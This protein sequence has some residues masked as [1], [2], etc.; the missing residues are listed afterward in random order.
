MHNLWCYRSSVLELNIL[1][2]QHSPNGTFK[3]GATSVSSSH[4]NAAVLLYD[5]DNVYS[6]DFSSQNLTKLL[7][8]TSDHR[9]TDIKQIMRID[10]QSVLALDT[11]SDAIFYVSATNQTPEA[12]VCAKEGCCKDSLRCHKSSSL[13][14]S[15]IAVLSNTKNIVYF[16]D[17]STIKKFQIG[18]SFIY[19]KVLVDFQNFVP[20]FGSIN[21]FAISKSYLRIFVLANS[22]VYRYN[23]DSK[24]ISGEIVLKNEEFVQNIVS[25]TENILLGKSG[26]AGAEPI[27]INF[28][29]DSATRICNSKE[30]RFA[31]NTNV[32]RNVT[33]CRNLFEIEEMVYDGS[34]I[35]IM[36]SDKRIR[37]INSVEG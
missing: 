6:W 19:P 22:V 27:V 28:D 3:L 37:V 11:N 18:E 16:S 9:F 7:S 10:D 32:L 15:K 4:V 5:N 26:E 13:G 14:I 17:R 31:K 20:D 23:I 29:N 33:N 1:K 12:L 30:I 25:L 34:Y 2:S 35:Y 21:S 24:Q 8:A 36:D